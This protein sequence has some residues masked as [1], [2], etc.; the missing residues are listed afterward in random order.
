MAVDQHI[1][2]SR[3]LQFQNDARQRGLAAAGF[4]DDAQIDGSAAGRLRLTS[5]TATRRVPKTKAAD[6]ED[7]ADIAQFQQIVAHEACSP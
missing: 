1:A 6:A 7:L 3:M 2:G 4:A 5:S